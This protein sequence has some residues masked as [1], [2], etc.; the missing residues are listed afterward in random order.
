MLQ[1]S[2]L[3][4]CLYFGGG[5]YKVQILAQLSVYGFP[6]L[7]WVSPY[8]FWD[9]TLKTSHYNFVLRPFQFIIRNHYTIE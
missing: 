4:S 9:N 5:E 1:L 7:S 3:Y 6:W 8:K 2:H